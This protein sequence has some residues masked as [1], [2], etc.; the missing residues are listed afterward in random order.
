MWVFCCGMYRSASTLQFQITAQL[1]QDAQIGQQIGWIDANRFSEVRCLY[2]DDPGL[3][4]IKVHKCTDAIIAEFI[5]SNALGIYTFRDIRDVY[6]SMMK[7]RQKSFDFLRHEGF[8]EACLENYKRWTILPNV[9]VSRYSDIIANPAEEV[10]RIA[11]HLQIPIDSSTCHTIAASYSLEAQKERIES[12]KARLM[13][14][15]QNPNDHRELVDYHDDSHLLHIN[16]IDAARVG[17][18]KDDF[19]E[20][21]VDWIEKQVEEWC[22]QNRYMSSVFLS[23]NVYA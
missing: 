14:M 12:L 18:W 19:S 20:Q 1:V 11:A 7:Q 9:L 23:E 6:A 4:V 13:K 8:L 16:H 17:R 3:K 10:R 2:Q 15:S 5:N 21:E 22:Q